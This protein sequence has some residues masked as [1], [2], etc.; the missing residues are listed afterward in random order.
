[1]QTILVHRPQRFFS[2]HYFADFTLNFDNSGTEFTVGLL[3]V[4]I[5]QEAS[6]PEIW[7]PLIGEPAFCN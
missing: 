7:I 5:A 3:P 6:W 2:A 1:M 4:G